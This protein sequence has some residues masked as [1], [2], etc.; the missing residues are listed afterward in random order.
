MTMDL[1][2]EDISGSNPVQTFTIVGEGFLVCG[3]PGVFL[4]SSLFAIV[5]CLVCALLT[6]HDEFC[7]V[8]Y[9]LILFATYSFRLSLFTFWAVGIVLGV[10]PALI[11]YWFLGTVFQKPQVK[12]DRLSTREISKLPRSILSNS[13]QR[14][15]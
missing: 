6:I 9:N 4:I 2:G 12:S 13:G 1:T 3:L 11:V 14:L 8:R 5:T 10:I 15:D 7:F